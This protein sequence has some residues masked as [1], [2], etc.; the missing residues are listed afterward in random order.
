MINSLLLS[1]SSSSPRLLLNHTKSPSIPITTSNL[2]ISNPAT[3]I[4]TPLRWTPQTLQFRVS[5][6]SANPTVKVASP[7][8]TDGDESADVVESGADVVR[9]FYGGVNRQDLGSV[10]GLIAEKC[11]YEDLVFPRPFVGRKVLLSLIHFSALF[12][13]AF[14]IWL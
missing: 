5:S 9:K 1:S 6:S 11:V 14:D 13:C 3:A 2:S 7:P 8:G 10:E 4:S 12:V